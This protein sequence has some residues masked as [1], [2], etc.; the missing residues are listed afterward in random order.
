ML[1]RGSGE[2]PLM[3]PNFSRVGAYSIVPAQDPNGAAG[4]SHRHTACSV[5]GQSE[6]VDAVLLR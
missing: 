4:C 3:K 5:V 6:S 1:S 2:Q